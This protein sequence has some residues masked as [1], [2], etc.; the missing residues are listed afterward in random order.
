MPIRIRGLTPRR[1]VRPVR[2]VC[3]VRPRTGPGAFAM[4]RMRRAGVRLAAVAALAVGLLLVSAGA[5][6]AHPLG[7]F[8]VN[9]YAGLRLLPDR[10]EVDYVVDMAEIPAFQTRQEIDADGDQSVSS[11]E[12]S[13][14]RSASCP[15]LAGG[16]V[17][18]LD[19]RRL[20][21]VTVAS[22]MSFPPGAGGL[23]TLRLEC[24]LATARGQ[25]PPSRTP[26]GGTLAGGTLAGETR[27]A[28]AGETRG[29]LAGGTLTLTNG[30]Y[31]GRVGWREV[32]AVGDGTTVTSRDVPAASASA[33]LTSYPKDL[34]RSPLDQR[35]ATVSFRP[36]GTAAA[37]AASEGGGPEAAPRR[38][39]VPMAVDRATRAFTELVARQRLGPAFGALAVAL[40][41]LL[42]AIHALAPG[43]G[44]TIMAA[45]LPGLRSSLS[46]ALL[47]AS[48][49]TLTHTAGVLALG[50]ALSASTALAPE[51]QDPL[52]G[53]ASGLLLASIG[54]TLLRRGSAHRPPPPRP[55]PRPL[56]RARS[57]ARARLR[58]PTWS[59][60]PAGPR[61]LG[62]PR[63]PASWSHASAG[64]RPGPPPAAGLAEPGIDGVRRRAR[65]QPVGPGR[66]AR[67]DRA[68]PC[69]V[70][71]AAGAGIRRWHGADSY[72][73][74]HAAGPGPRRGRPARRGRP[75]R[76]ARPGRCLP[77]VGACG[78]RLGLAGLSRALPLASA[79]AIIAVGL[80]L[81]AQGASGI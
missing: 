18:R 71:R 65:A 78:P 14:W 63:R 38:A 9:Q 73:L 12:A 26:A 37:G 23:P 41:L 19:G 79:A 27:G 34:L 1:P 59:H 40:A 76:R 30:D 66:A 53:L 44:K 50:I 58:R 29:T 52:L 36:G 33:R 5:A 81:A 25:A 61:W 67:R 57:L 48:T 31:A 20:D 10:V 6:A 45:Y 2:P 47:V 42:G 43:H 54:V 69:L 62:R 80:F 3:A 51:R 49:V 22:R 60:A 39:A 21:L 56:G 35:A 74:W 72:R 8:T 17:L 16:L 24:G 11:A 28:L 13:A 77:S 55:P 70:R 7:N 68:R 32:T 4:V 64:R 75:G 15:R 46:Q